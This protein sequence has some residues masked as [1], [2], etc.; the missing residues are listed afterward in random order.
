MRLTSNDVS[1]IKETTMRHFGATAGVWLF[2]SR[3]DEERRGGD[4]DLLVDSGLSDADAVVRARIAFLTDLKRRIGERKID[5]L[6]DF[7]AR[8]SRPPIFRIAREQ[9]VRL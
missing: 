7:P 4:I 1:A 3:L 6:V 5:L 2:G 8:T 9:G